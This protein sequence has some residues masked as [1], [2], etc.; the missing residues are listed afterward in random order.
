MHLKVIQRQMNMSKLGLNA[1]G[2]IPKNVGV[3][4][5]LSDT[6]FEHAITNSAH[7]LMAES[8]VDP[9]SNGEGSS[10]SSPNSGT[11]VASSSS[12]PRPRSPFNFNFGLPNFPASQQPS[13]EDEGRINPLAGMGLTDEQYNLI[14]QNIVSGDGFLDGMDNLVSSSSSSSAIPSGSG[15]GSSSA[16]ASGDGTGFLGSEVSTPTPS[17]GMYAGGGM[18]MG[19]EKRRLEEEGESQNDG[20]MKRGRYEVG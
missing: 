12:T 4:P 9:N 20:K 19:G 14:L 15:L 10:S 1:L 7:Q 17:M 6:N 16:Y 3:L 13:E 5:P 8:G 18:M 2:S 11:M